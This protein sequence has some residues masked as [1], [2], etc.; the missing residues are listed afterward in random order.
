MT[1]AYGLLLS[2]NS[3][4][5]SRGNADIVGKYDATSGAAVSA[6][7]VTGLSI[8]TGMAILGNNLFVT[9]LTANKVGEYDATTGAAI[10]ANFITG[11]V[12]NNP[13][14]LAIL[15]NNL[16]VANSG[17]TTVGEF[18]ATN[19]SV[20]NASFIN[21]SSRSPVSLT[22]VPEP[23][24]GSLIAVAGFGWL[25]RRRR[26]RSASKHGQSGESSNSFLRLSAAQQA[27]HDGP[28]G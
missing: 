27:E 24:A 20:I 7:F 12:I 16:F 17:T 19:G 13:E 14:D 5:V 11:F 26:Q 25:L 6:N 23:S 18:N 3:L 21:L 4:F 8:A 15:G 22:L 28:L 2:G 9:S 1:G 10:N